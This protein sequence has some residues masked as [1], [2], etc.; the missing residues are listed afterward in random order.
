MKVSIITICYNNE[1]DILPTIKSVVNQTYQNIEYIIVDGAS[2]DKTLEIVK[3]FGNKI[4]KVI[5]EPD[6]G[7]YDAIN[8]GLALATG[9]IVGLIHAGD[10]LHDNK[11]I[12]DIVKNFQTN[13]IDISYGNSKIVEG[14]KVKRVNISPS[15]SLFHVKTGWMPSHQSI[16]VKRE[17]IDKLGGYRLDLHPDADYEWFIRFFICNKLKINRLNRF[18]VK[19]SLGGVSTSSYNKRL[20]QDYKNRVNQSWV[21]NGLKPPFCIFY[22]KLLRKIPQFILAKFY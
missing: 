6:K 2:K 7:L 13:E 15:Y 14:D 10:M 1:K 19:F 21:L 11:V 20:K 22:T 17:L 16:Y 5:S 3:S 12:E 8:K 4:T 9:D 18:I